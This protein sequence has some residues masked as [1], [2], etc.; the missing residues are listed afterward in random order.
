MTL[1]NVTAALVRLR[2]EMPAIRRWGTRGFWAVTDQALFAGAN[3]LVNILLARW[4][5][6]AEYGAFAVTY[7]VLILAGNF[8]SAFYVEPMLVYGAKSFRDRFDAYYR[9][10]TRAHWSVAAPFAVSLLAV[11]ALISFNSG[12]AMMGTAWLGA[13]VASPCILALNLARRAEY[14][15]LRPQYAA[16]AG[17]AY[18]SIFVAAAFA[19]TS[20]SLLDSLTAYGTLSLA[21]LLAAWSISGSG[22]GSVLPEPEAAWARELHIRYGKWAA[23]ASILLWVCGQAVYPL[24]AGLRGLE[25]AATLRAVLTFLLPLQHMLA[26]SSALLVPAFARDKGERVTTRL[27][28]AGTILCGVAALYALLLMQYGAWLVGW[29]LGGNYQEMAGPFLSLAALV[30]LPVALRTLAFARLRAAAHTGTIATISVAGALAAVGSGVGL[31]IWMGVSGALLSLLLGEAILA[32]GGLI[33]LK[34]I[35]RSSIQCR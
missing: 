7:S 31:I 25:A 6:P 32:F 3:F 27:M 30:P 10:I 22:R 19:L 13:A 33:A 4:L 18:L 21:A 14:V 20:T 16:V 8:H 24:L 2:A 1:P 23:V 35:L 34:R 26:A 29:L 12:S 15:L 28:V 11:V 17:M 9:T 5:E